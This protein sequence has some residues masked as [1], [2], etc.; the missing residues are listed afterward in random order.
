[1][2]LLLL[3][4]PYGAAAPVVVVEDTHDGLK[5]DRDRKR[6]Q[7]RLRAQLEAAFE[8]R[9]GAP[10]QEALAEFIAPQVAD[11]IDR[12]AIERIVWERVWKRY[13]EVARRLE[14]IARKAA[15]DDEDDTFLLIS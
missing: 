3:F 13:D 11:S 4:R 10:V 9:Y 7:E 12:P 6:D 14:Q 8:S 15:E 5:R 1:M 2:S